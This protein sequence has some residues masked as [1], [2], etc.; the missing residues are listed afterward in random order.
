MKRKNKWRA[1]GYYTG[2]T[3]YEHII[4]EYLETSCIKHKIPF[5]IAGIPD[6]GSWY[7]N[8]AYKPKFVM[9]M[10]NSNPKDECIVLL[11]ADST[12]EKYPI[13]FDEIPE[14]YD[15]AFHVLDWNSWYGHTN[16]IKELLTGTMFLRNNDKVRK[17][18]EEWFDIAWNTMEWEQKVLQKILDKHDVKCYNLPIEYC[19]MKSR[20]GDLEP[21]VKADPIILHYQASR[22]YKRSVRKD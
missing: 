20:P 8:T 12:I 21:L 15:I 18:C 17:L 3:P 11:D 5:T 14:E 2:N 13:L 10:L 7:K 1:C 19:Y 9:E 22:K 6:Y 16:N 4:R